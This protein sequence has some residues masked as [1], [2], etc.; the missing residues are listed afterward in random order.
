MKSLIA[1]SYHLFQTHSMAGVQ[2]CLRGKR[3]LALE[4][5]TTSKAAQRNSIQ[6]HKQVSQTWSKPKLKRGVLLNYFRRDWWRVTT[7]TQSSNTGVRY[8]NVVIRDAHL[9]SNSERLEKPSEFWRQ[10]NNSTWQNKY[11]SLWLSSMRGPGGREHRGKL[12]TWGGNRQRDKGFQLNGS[13]AWQS[14][15]DVGHFSSGEYN[16]Q[17]KK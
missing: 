2:N 15:F 4:V 8:T 13:K 9:L 11:L 12:G 6:D 5:S 14:A 1:W 16:K 7:T 10:E 3:L 17:T